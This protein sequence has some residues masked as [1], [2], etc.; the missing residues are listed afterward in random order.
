ML[1]SFSIR[2]AFSLLELLV[3]IM[4]VSIVYFLGFNGIEKEEKRPQTLTPLNLKTTIQN[5]AFFRGEGTLLCV[6]ECQSCYFRTTID[7]TFQAYKNKIDLY[8]TKVYTLDSQNSLQEQDAGRYQ[9]HKI[10]LVMDFYQNGSTSQLI[11]ETPQ[12][13]YFLPAFFGEP[14]KVDSLD[15]AKALWLKANDLASGSGDFY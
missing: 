1:L 8:G 7:S 3:T 5:S 11:L 9:D 10:C 14:Q 4:I 2:R 12:G 13:I 6:N 15:E